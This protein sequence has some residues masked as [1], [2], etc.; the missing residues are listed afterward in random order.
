MKLI[1][2]TGLSG[3]GKSVALNTLEDIGYYCIDNLPGFL[4]ASFTEALVP[5]RDQRYRLS[6][7]GI[8]ARDRS[9]DFGD[10]TYLLDTLR[11][12][13]VDYR[14]I[15]LDAKDDT[16]IKR[17]SETRRKHPL[18]D[19]EHPL[20]EAIELERKILKPFLDKATLQVDTT[21][22]NLHQLRDI[23]RSKV[24]EQAGPE[25]SLQ[26][27]SFGFKHGMPRDADFVYDVRCLPNP[28]WQ[29]E[30]RPLT[31]RDPE[32][33]RFLEQDSNVRQFKADVIEFL[34]RWIPCFEA[35]GRSYLTIAIGCTGGQ[36]RSVYMV[37]EI[38]AHFRTS[39]LKILSRHRELT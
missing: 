29:N 26:F 27:Q 37:E 4:L 19:D 8:D 2:V 6:A 5:S 7:V 14:I 28:H 15:F 33:A 13:G 1:I 11:S 23:I 21:H 20:T 17:F 38:S 3:S 18:S 24:S 9:S 16:L 12:K 22:T 25:I 34:E 32:V 31:G 36:H 30:L 39:G 10:I 35:D